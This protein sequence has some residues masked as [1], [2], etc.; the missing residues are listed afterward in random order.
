MTNN[1]KYI[2][3]YL[4][5]LAHIFSKLLKLD[6]TRFSLTKLYNSFWNPINYAII[7][8]IGLLIN[9][10]ILLT[11]AL[12]LPLWLANLVAILTAWSWNWSMSVGPFGW[13]WGFKERSK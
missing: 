12:I 3:F 1:L 5:K 8:G 9:M 6:N 4:S 13:L 2:P 11:L 10:I 7:G